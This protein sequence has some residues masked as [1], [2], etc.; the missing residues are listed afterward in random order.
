M[1]NLQVE[2]RREITFSQNIILINDFTELIISENSDTN[3]GVTYLKEL[4]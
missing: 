2:N 4:R 1:T 3:Y